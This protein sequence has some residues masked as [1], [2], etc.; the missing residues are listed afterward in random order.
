MEVT[1]IHD[2]KKKANLMNAEANPLLRSRVYWMDN[3]RTITILFV[4]LY[5]IGGVYESA[6]LWGWFW[7]VDDPTTMVWV[8]IMGIIFDIFAMPTLFFVSGYLTVASLKNKPTGKFIMGKSS[9]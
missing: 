3:L 2:T 1:S 6:G 4:V 9:D 8:G 5:H 7:I